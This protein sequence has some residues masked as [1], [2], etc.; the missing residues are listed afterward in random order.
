MPEEE[1]GRWLTYA[2]AGQLLGISAAAA[3]MYAKRHGWQRRTPNAYGDRA[4]VLVPMEAN[5]QPRSALYGERTAH[6]IT[7]DQGDPNGTDQVNVQVIA[8]AIEALR[9]Q[10]GI[11]NSRADRAERQIEVERQRIDE[12]L[13]QLADGSE[14]GPGTD[15]MTAIGIQTL[16]Q[17]I[18]MLR[19]DVDRE[20][21]RA[22]RSER[23]IEDG[24]KRVDDLLIELADART[25]AMISGADAAAL[26]TQLA[27]LTGPRAPW[28]RRWF[29]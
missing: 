19:E 11:A 18:E 2:E 5:V 12:L 15:P 25:A 20:R 28:W 17:A 21:D 7:R 27:L 3:R 23:Q 16:S 26:R 29:R 9:E 4:R 6:V 13:H 10:L 24:C 1:E 22:D 14:R 8:Q